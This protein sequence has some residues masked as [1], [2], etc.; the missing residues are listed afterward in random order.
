MNLF[1]IKKPFVLTIFGASGDLAKLKIFPALYSLMQ[2]GRFPPD[3]FIV[4]FAR[5]RKSRA[6][7]QKEFEESIVAN[8]RDDVDRKILKRLVNAVHYFTGT[9]DRLADYKGYRLF[10]KKLTSSHERLPHIAYFS[11]PP[12]I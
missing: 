5:T 7:F 6:E 4:G 11:V 9:Y 10:L 3:F 1:K 2:Q 12:T 8:L